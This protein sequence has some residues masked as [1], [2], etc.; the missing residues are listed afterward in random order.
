MNEMPKPW[1]PSYLGKISIEKSVTCG[2]C[3]R[4]HGG[5]KGV[6]ELVTMGW[7]KRDLKVGW[8]CPDCAPS[9]TPEAV[10]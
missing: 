9:P 3:E 5:I 4:Y 2:R 10:R 1:R 7:Q 8:L 6:A